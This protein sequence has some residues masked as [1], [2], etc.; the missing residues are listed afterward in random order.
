MKISK[1]IV[2]LITTITLTVAGIAASLITGAVI[3]KSHSSEAADMEYRISNYKVGNVGLTIRDASQLP[4]NS[5]YKLNGIGGDFP[6]SAGGVFLEFGEYPR[7]FVGNT[8]NAELEDL[9]S[10]SLGNELVAT[11]K[12]YTSNSYT[13]HTGQWVNQTARYEGRESD[14]YIYR[15]K[16]YVR[17]DVLRFSN[18]ET[19]EA[20]TNAINET[21]GELYG[22][23]SSE[24]N[25][26]ATG[27]VAWFHVEP[28]R[29][30][31]ANWSEMPTS[32][33]PNGKTNNAAS[34]MQLLAIDQIMA[35]VPHQPLG[36]VPPYDEVLWQYSR[37]RTFLNGT[38]NDENR[39]ALA[40]AGDSPTNGTITGNPF[41]VDA[42]TESQRA[43][44]Q[45][46]TIRNS[47]TP[48]T[49]EPEI[50]VK[51]PDIISINEYDETRTTEDKIFTLS[52]R[53][54][55]GTPDALDGLYRDLFDE[56]TEASRSRIVANTDWAFGNLAWSNDTSVETLGEVVQECNLW[57]AGAWWLRSSYSTNR[58]ARVYY[59]GEEF[60]C[61]TYNPSYGM[62]PAMY[63]SIENIA[64]AV[65]NKKEATTHLK[66]L[67]N[68]L[69]S[70]TVTENSISE[71]N[72][73]ANKLVS[74]FDFFDKQQLKN[75]LE[76][77]ASVNDLGTPSNQNEINTYKAQ[78]TELRNLI[79][80]LPTYSDLTSEHID[81]FII[82]LI[83]AGGVLAVGTAAAILIIVCQRSKRNAVQE[84]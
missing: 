18:L 45:T 70:Q 41:I 75:A 8:K 59:N 25:L 32:I 27:T 84:N 14:E 16:K 23:E 66:N 2:A 30:L 79:E 43:L 15:G 34:T 74:D 82:G 20:R 19:D 62:R 22:R 40:N 26:F 39:Q 11:G 5:T 12:T 81:P 65:T 7:S 38:T 68:N 67:I 48:E 36:L 10:T 24:N 78:A 71:I 29:W 72:I 21:T 28:L 57:G 69:S 53:Q 4:A 60:R 50:L 80:Q 49:Y 47:K 61:F 83:C 1:K 3:S 77:L 33:N 6:T 13:P 58:I 56:G 64:H 73:Y 55:F 37:V 54:V 31:I 51:N 46:Q 52:Y 9:F 76:K 42:F 63:L 35:G 17:H 44:I